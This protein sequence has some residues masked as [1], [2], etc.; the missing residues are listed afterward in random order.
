MGFFGG[1]GKAV[2][3]V[4]GGVNKAGGAMTPGKFMMPGPGNNKKPGLGP[5]NIGQPL[6]I[7][8]PTNIGEAQQVNGPGNQ[9][10]QMAQQM[11]GPGASPYGSVS[12]SH[13]NPIRGAMGGMFGMGGGGK[14]MPM[15]QNKM[16]PP[17]QMQRPM[18][19]NYTAPNTWQADNGS[20]MRG[21]MPDPMARWN[22][23]GGGIAYNPY[24]DQNATPPT[25]PLLQRAPGLGPS[26]GG[27]GGEQP[28]Q[29]WS[30]R[31]RP[32]VE[33]TQPYNY[34]QPPIGL[35]GQQNRLDQMGGGMRGP[36]GGGM[37]PGA[38]N[39]RNRAPYM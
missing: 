35:D 24:T 17:Q 13:M 32:Q 16:V 10:G 11:R 33:P 28:G 20:Q 15:P 25:G 3:K 14:G 37:F 19:D 5:T 21:N 6:S 18:R 34:N 36:V 29:D 22:G 2:N 8:G 23:G 31:M 12:Q 7:N 27:G 38:M 1:I 4:V 26:W 9:A 39:I 30:G